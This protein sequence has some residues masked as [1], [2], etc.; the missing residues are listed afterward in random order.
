MNKYNENKTWFLGA[1][2]EYAAFSLYHL[3]LLLWY[4]QTQMPADRFQLPGSLIC[5]VPAW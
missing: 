1:I 3:K 5:E 2:S 4:A